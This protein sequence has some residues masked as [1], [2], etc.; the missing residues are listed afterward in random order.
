MDTKPVFGGRIRSYFYRF[1][2]EKDISLNL[3]LVHRMH[4]VGYP[5]RAATP[6]RATKIIHSYILV[7]LFSSYP[8]EEKKWM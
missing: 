5:S 3:A 8:Y 4:G 7:M 6:K 2:A 1:E